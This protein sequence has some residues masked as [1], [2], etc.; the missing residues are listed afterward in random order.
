MR[1]LV[2]VAI[3]VSVTASAV[4]GWA[5]YKLN[6]TEPQPAAPVAVA[7]EVEHEIE[8]GDKMF[9]MARRFSSLWYA[10]E[11]GNVEL[12]L[13]EL[14]EMHEVVEEI[15]EANPI[16]NG[17]RI[18]G[19]LDAVERTQ[20]EAMRKAL[21]AKDPVGF[22]RAYHD[23]IEMCNSC[24][25]STKHTFIKIEVPNAPPMRNRRWDYTGEDV[26]QAAAT[27]D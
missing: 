11:N 18:A 22:K 17:V 13:Y 4:A 21:V 6:K 12:G 3:A 9:T 26:V 20:F 8:L 19:V 10:G 7:P 27:S 23:T 5:C 14:H 15:A 16:E 1:I 24:H 2:S 25:T